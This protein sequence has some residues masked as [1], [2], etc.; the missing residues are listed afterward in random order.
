MHQ[1]NLFWSL[2][3]LLC[4]CDGPPTGQRT[5]WTPTDHDTNAAGKGSP[6]AQGP[7][8]APVATP[9]GSGGADSAGKFADL[10][11]QTQC[12]NCHGPQGNGDGPMAKTSGAVRIAAKDLQDRLTDEQIANSIRNGKGKMPKYDVDDG[13]LKAL[14]AKVRSLRERSP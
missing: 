4:A 11:W 6:T 5:A 14:V 13:V 9:S 1:R 10:T 2:A 7:R 3:W 8:A 12:A